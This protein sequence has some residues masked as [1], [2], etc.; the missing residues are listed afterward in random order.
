MIVEK[1]INFIDR[2]VFFCF[3]ISLA[4]LPLY[5]N[6]I[7]ISTFIVLP[8]SFIYL[9][10]SNNSV[11]YSFEPFHKR[12][13][14]FFF[15]AIVSL[16]FVESL[17]D[18][19][20]EIKRLFG[21]LLMISIC[22]MYIKRNPLN[23]YRF[24]FI[25]LCKYIFMLIFTYKYGLDEIDFGNRLKS[26]EDVGIN[27]NAFGYFAFISLFI[28][29][30]L[31]LLKKNIWTISIFILFFLTGIIINAL[32]ASRAGILFSF[33]SFI[34]ILNSVYYKKIYIKVFILLIISIP[35]LNSSMSNFDFESLSIIGRFNNFL[36]TSEDQ[37]FEILQEGIGVFLNKPF[38]NGG[39]QFESLML[40]SDF[41]KIAASHNSFML[42]L[43]NYGIHSLFIFLS[44]FLLSFRDSQKL[45]RGN[46]LSKNK[47]GLL[48]LSFFLLFFLY[49][50]FYDFVL[51]LYIMLMF[52]LVY[53]HQRLIL[54][55]IIS[56]IYTR[57]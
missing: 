27:A 45:I 25:I 41:N 17:N 1:K 30:I 10:T 26:G 47:F 46:D 53:M 44:L 13:L 51:D 35:I 54:K 43:V 18:Y 38:G 37:R 15:F 24:Y 56:T 48:F 5:S 23:I 57:K 21:V 33:M 7:W 36:E 8:L 28:V 4:I 12:L 32:A 29:G 3:F 2:V 19:I 16:I 11:K 55:N 14:L 22:F 49:N 52:A 34:L 9:I 31:L 39:G 50:L 6:L 42:I 40:K 20:F